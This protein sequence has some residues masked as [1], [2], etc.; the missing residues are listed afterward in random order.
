[1]IHYV[2]GKVPRQAH[3]G[4]PE[5]PEPEPL[6]EEG[7]E[8]ELRIQR[9]GEYTSIFYDFYPFDVEEP[10]LVTSEAEAVEMNYAKVWRKE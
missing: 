10:L 6:T 7:N 1:M 2:K 4:I 5:T 3:V 9:G 8:W